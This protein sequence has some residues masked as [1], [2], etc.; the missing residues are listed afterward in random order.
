MRRSKEETRETISKLINV[1]RYHFTEKGYAD[2]ALEEIVDEAGMT[3]GA[4]YH[5]FKSKK[6]LFQNVLELVQ[7]EIAECV[8]T[9]AAKSEDAWEQLYLGCEA[10]VSAAIES[11]NK[12]ILLIDGPAVLGW[13]VW[14]RMDEQNSMRL[15]REQ[16]LMMQDVGYMKPISVD[17]LTHTLSGALNESALWIAQI[18]DGR[19][20]FVETMDV[21]KLMFEGLKAK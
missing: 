18:S 10:F 12:R 11:Q 17:G 9:E 6:E 1:A 4:L 2:T 5:H 15:M 3:R 21:I 19:R 13:E 8:E 7:K 16:L 14:R 20:A